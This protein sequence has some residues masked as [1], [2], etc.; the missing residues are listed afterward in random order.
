MTYR[1]AIRVV[2]A[3]GL[4][5]ALVETAVRSAAF[6]GAARRGACRPGGCDGCGLAPLLAAARSEGP[7]EQAVK[8]GPPRGDLLIA[9]FEGDTWGDWKTKGEAFGKGPAKGTLPG[10]MPVSGFKGERL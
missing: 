10:Q 3:V 8:A 9:D 2:L 4:V 1:S 5:A 6:D 7:P